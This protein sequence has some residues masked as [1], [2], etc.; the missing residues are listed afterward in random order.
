MAKVLGTF[1]LG[2]RTY[3]VGEDFD[4]HRTAISSRALRS[5]V[6]MGMIAS[7]DAKPRPEAPVAAEKPI[8]AQP[9][10]KPVMEHTGGGW[11]D[12]TI[13]GEVQKVHGKA[14]AEALIAEN[15]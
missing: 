15:G 1:R 12:V 7:G 8:A 4:P 3:F 10:Q 11:Y 14:A 5:L 6:S 9:A 2:G 13:N